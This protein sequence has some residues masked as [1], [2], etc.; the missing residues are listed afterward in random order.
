MDAPLR[1]PVALRRGARWFRLAHAVAPDAL[2]LG[3]ALPDELDGPIEVAFHLPGDREAVRCHGA[4]FEVVV[5]EGDLERA[6]RRGVR[7]VDLDPEARTRI[8][9]YIEERLGLTT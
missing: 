1:V 4:A 2:E 3:C 6:E 7:L 5:G 9:K 8:Q